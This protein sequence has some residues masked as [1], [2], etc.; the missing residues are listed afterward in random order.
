MKN[1][2]ILCMCPCITI[3]HPITSLILLFLSFDLII[4]PIRFP[5]HT[6][7]SQEQSDHCSFVWVSE[8]LWP[9]FQLHGHTCFMLLY[10][11]WNFPCGLSGILTIMKSYI[12]WFVQSICSEKPWENFHNNMSCYS[13]SLSLLLSVWQFVSQRHNNSSNQI[14]GKA[15]K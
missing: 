15:I 13:L 9:Q 7:Q 1:Q 11:F 8:K 2:C 5:F 4:I 6:V 12:V 3:F 14:K 10:G